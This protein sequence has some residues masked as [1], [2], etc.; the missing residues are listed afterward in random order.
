MGNN[1]SQQLEKRKAKRAQTLTPLQKP[2][3]RFST[4]TLVA[5]VGLG[6]RSSPSS[7]VPAT[8]PIKAAAPEPASPQM[9]QEQE[10]EQEPQR[11]SE[12]P[13]VPSQTEKEN[14]PESVPEVSLDLSH[15]LQLLFSSSSNLLST[16]CSINRQLGLLRT[17]SSYY[18]LSTRY[19]SLSGTRFIFGSTV[20]PQAA[21]VN[22]SFSSMLAG[23]RL[24][25]I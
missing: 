6:K 20:I 3:R 19:R 23:F 10:S 7:L 25:A 2:P 9:G 13:P 12:P 15:R 5:S 22:E 11:E 17:S 1:V 8:S 14:Q 4:N 24:L 16:R 21:G 18:A